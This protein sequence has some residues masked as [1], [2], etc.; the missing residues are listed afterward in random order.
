MQKAS[1]RACRQSQPPHVIRGVC[2][3]QQFEVPPSG[4]ANVP[5]VCPALCGLL[6]SLSQ[7]SPPR[8]D[9]EPQ[10]SLA[11]PAHSAGVTRDAMDLV[12]DALDAIYLAHL[13]DRTEKIIALAHDAT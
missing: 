7:R 1:D 4:P 6:V 8:G 13:F 10:L 11:R 5:T 9:Y 12:V 3:G 2:L